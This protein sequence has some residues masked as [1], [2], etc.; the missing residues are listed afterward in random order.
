MSFLNRYNRGGQ[1]SVLLEDNVGWMEL[2]A[3]IARRVTTSLK[4]LGTTWRA[5]KTKYYISDV[6]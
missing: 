1:G 6:G 4:L 2:M 5:A 3:D